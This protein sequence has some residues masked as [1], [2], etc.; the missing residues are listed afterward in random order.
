MDPPA[1]AHDHPGAAR[2]DHPGCRPKRPRSDGGTPART[3]VVGGPATG[4]AAS[5]PFGPGT[6]P[7]RAGGCGGRPATPPSDSGSSGALPGD[8]PAVRPPPSARAS[9]G[10]GRGCGCGRGRRGRCGGSAG[11]GASS[12]PRGGP[13]RPASRPHPGRYARPGQGPRWRRRHHGPGAVTGPGDGTGAPAAGAGSRRPSAAP[14]GRAP[15]RRQ[16]AGT[17]A[18]CRA[19]RPARLPAGAFARVVD[20][21]LITRLITWVGCGEDQP[22]GAGVGPGQSPAPGRHT[23]GAPADSAGAPLVVAFDQSRGSC[24]RPPSAGRPEEVSS[25]ADSAAA[26]PW[27]SWRCSSSTRLGSSMGVKK[28]RIARRAPPT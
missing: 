22:A 11:T 19:T 12:G 10:R 8:P 16:G 4:D 3:S 7:R 5:P 26:C 1:A 25:R 17:T 2:R 15:G 28:P 21:R 20:A 18:R 23:S 14:Q 6:P 9:R 24:G 27:S 13:A